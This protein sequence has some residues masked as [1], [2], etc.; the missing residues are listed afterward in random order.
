MDRTSCPILLLAHCPIFLK[1]FSRNDRRRREFVDGDH[2]P[3]VKPRLDHRR[4]K[5]A[6]PFFGIGFEIRQRIRRDRLTAS[7][8]PV[9]TRMLRPRKAKPIKPN[10]AAIMSNEPD[11]FP[12]DWTLRVDGLLD[13]LS[14]RVPS[15]ATTR[16]VHWDAAS[17]AETEDDL[18]SA[19][20]TNIHR[21]DD[22]CPS[23]IVAD[24]K[25]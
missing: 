18:L 5:M 12:A 20:S 16:K 19:L 3:F 21:F 22:T 6:P 23:S 14:I 15:V 8:I 11:Y 25:L 13:R 1:G 7:A 17:I 9:E 10:A 2:V 4:A 24:F